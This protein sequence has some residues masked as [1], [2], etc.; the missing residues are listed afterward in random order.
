MHESHR[1]L[2]TEKKTRRIPYVKADEEDRLP[3]DSR[4]G[5]GASLV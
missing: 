2:K 1:S 3:N 5:C 4:A